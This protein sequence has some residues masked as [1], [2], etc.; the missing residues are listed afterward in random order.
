[1]RGVDPVGRADAIRARVPEVLRMYSETRRNVLAGGILDSGIKELCARYLAEDPELVEFEDA[2]ALNERERAALD[3]AQAIVWDPSL[4]DDAL[5]ARLHA[6]F[7]EPELVELGYYIAIVHGQLHW[8]RTLGLRPERH[9]I[10]A[11]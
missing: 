7:T 4:A 9:E 3:W 1:M 10:L 2:D 6:Q 5:W 8:L 11:F